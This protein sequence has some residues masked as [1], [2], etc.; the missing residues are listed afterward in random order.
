MALTQRGVRGWTWGT[1]GV[2]DDPANPFQT[3]NIAINTAAAVGSENKQEWNK[4]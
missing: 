1:W 2:N 3:P 4:I